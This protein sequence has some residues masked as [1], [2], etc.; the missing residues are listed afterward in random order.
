M[1]ISFF[2]WATATFAFKVWWLTL[3]YHYHLYMCLYIYIYIVTNHQQVKVWDSSLS[4]LSL[5]QRWWPRR[6]RWTWPSYRWSSGTTAPTTSWNSWSVS[7]TTGQTS[8]PATMRDTTGTTASTW[9]KSTPI[10]ASWFYGGDRKSKNEMLLYHWWKY[11]HYSIL[12]L[13]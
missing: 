3:I 12:K 4:S 8:W 11:I 1:H 10:H 9:S 7:G 13:M 5:R 6:S 2:L